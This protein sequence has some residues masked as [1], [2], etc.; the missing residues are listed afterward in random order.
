M[1]NKALL[2]GINQYP[3]PRNSLRGCVNDI[4]DM[5]EYICHSR[6]IF[7]NDQVRF[8]TDKEATKIEIIQQIKW[9][10]E[11][12]T[13][14]DQILFHFSGHGAQVRS[15][16]ST[17]EKDGLDEIICP[18]D[19]DG[20]EATMIR[21]KEFASLFSRIPKGV[22]FTWISDSCHAEDLSRAQIASGQQYRFYLH[23]HDL[24]L[25]PRLI[26]E[27]APLS[28]SGSN[29]TTLEGVLLSACQSHQ[30]SADA[31][32]ENRFNGAFTHYLLKNLRKFGENTPL[33][34]LI[35]KVQKDLSQN[36]YD[37]DP[38]VEGLLADKLFLPS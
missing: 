32:I 9:L 1:Q 12:A 28:R 19:Y 11:G 5:R 37:Q 26:E 17:T 7:K 30:L 3:D 18:Y 8:I 23:H 20:Q 33:R 22:N 15:K 21:D 16:N 6:K 29:Q 25:R 2:V 38:S 10:L 14:G 13:L 27:V 36:G 34:L 35:K 4:I 24:P 31:Y